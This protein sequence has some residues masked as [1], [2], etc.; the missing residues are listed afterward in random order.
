SD[1]PLGQFEK[2]TKGIGS[3]LM[4]KMGFNRTG[5]SKNRQGDANP[6]QVEDQ[7]QFTGLGYSSGK[8]EIGESSKVAEGRQAS[9]SQG[10]TPLE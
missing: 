5:L 8:M 4:V 10:S 6:V 7:P 1:I 3:K 2:H 9:N